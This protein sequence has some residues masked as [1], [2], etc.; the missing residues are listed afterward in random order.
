MQVPAKPDPDYCQSWFNHS[1]T[2]WL[3][4][5]LKKQHQEELEYIADI[6]S[7]NEESFLHSVYQSQAVA[8]TLRAIITGFEK[9]GGISDE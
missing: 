3:L 1:V 4:A 2:Q 8:A 9:M 5:D 6:V 7:S